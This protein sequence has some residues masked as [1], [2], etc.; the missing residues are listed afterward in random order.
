MTRSTSKAVQDAGLERL[1]GVSSISHHKMCPRRDNKVAS[2]LREQT[3]A[4][5]S[6]ESLTQARH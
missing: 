6:H 4:G 5:D 1:L 2:V 3:N